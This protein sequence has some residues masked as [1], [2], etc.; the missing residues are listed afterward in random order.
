M[1]AFLTTESRLQLVRRGEKPSTTNIHPLS[2][3]ILYNAGSGATREI[4][5]VVKEAFGKEIYLDFTVPRILLLRVG[6][7]FGGVPPDPRDALPVMLNYELLDDQGDGIRS[8]VG[9]MV[10]LLVLKRSLFLIDEPEAFLYPPQAF[11]IGSLIA[12][13]ADRSRQIILATHSADVLRGIL[14]RTSDVDI[15]RIDRVGNV[16]SFKRLDPARLK[17][18]INDPLLTSSRVLE[19]LFYSG[20]VVVEADSDARFYH[21]ASTKRLRNL[22]LHFVNADNKQTVPRIVRLYADMGVRTVGIVD[23]DVLNDRAEL[24]KSLETVGL[25]DEEV[26][27]LLDAQSQIGQAA[28]DLPSEERLQSI[29]AK[30]TEVMVNLEQVVGQKFESP[31]EEQRAKDALL[32]QMENRF[33]EM[34]DMTKAWK[35]FKQSGRCALPPD[36]Q[37]AFDRLWKKCA[38]QGFFI[39]PC[40]EL[41][42]MLIGYGI[43][44]TTDKKDWITRSLKLVPEIDPNDEKY[45]WKF[46]KAIQEYIQ[47]GG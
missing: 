21:A 5:A 34:A 31:E 11:R 43:P 35:T 28:K 47:A 40:G 16:N 19:G 15:I 22:D 14:S 7:D 9:V 24:K 2:L 25:L 27:T 26:Q 44:W 32:R 33:R 3:Q 20:A 13:Q 38:A 42:S 39:N 36:A 1:V 12:E 30:L 10:T 6:D 41:E 4:I 18:I 46:L 8:F 37:A 17:E 45:P 29:R 23:F